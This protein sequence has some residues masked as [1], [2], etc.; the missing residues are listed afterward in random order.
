LH[1]VGWFARDAS[2]LRQV[3]L[4]LLPMNLVELKRTRRIIFADDLFQLSNVPSQKTVY[5]IDRA[6]ENLSGCKFLYIRRPIYGSFIHI[7]IIFMA[8]SLDC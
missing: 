8:D 6:I 2:V 4:V 5:I 7:N 3:G 1:N